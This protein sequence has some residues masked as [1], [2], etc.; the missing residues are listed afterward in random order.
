MVADTYTVTPLPLPNYSNSTAA[1]HTLSSLP[2]TDGYA[3]VASL[4]DLIE[5]SGTRLWIWALDTI[6]AKSVV[7]IL[8]FDELIGLPFISVAAPWIRGLTIDFNAVATA[9]NL[10]RFQDLRRHACRS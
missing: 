3:V 4:A 8:T 9:S 10:T 5:P 1:S 2:Y 7:Y 6:G